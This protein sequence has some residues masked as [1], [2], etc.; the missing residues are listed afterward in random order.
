MNLSFYRDNNVMIY[1]EIRSESRKLMRL[2]SQCAAELLS[3]PLRK[4]YIR[5]LSFMW[6]RPPNSSPRISIEK[7]ER[8]MRSYLISN[9][10]GKVQRPSIFITNFLL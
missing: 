2:H 5:K 10:D 1:R 8:L 4:F 6:E 3:H 9:L 7:S